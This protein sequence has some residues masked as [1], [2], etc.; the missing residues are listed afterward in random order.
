MLFVAKAFQ[1]QTLV[2]KASKD[3]DSHVVYI[4]R[5]QNLALIVWAHGP[6]T[7]AKRIQVAFRCYIPQ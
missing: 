4:D 1:P 6:L 3:V 2:G 7:W 5:V